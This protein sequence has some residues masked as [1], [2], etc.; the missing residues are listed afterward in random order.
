[1]F[2]PECTTSSKDSDDTGASTPLLGAPSIT[3]DEPLDVQTYCLFLLF[4]MGVSWAMPDL[5][6]VQVPYFERFQPESTNLALHF[7]VSVSITAVLFVPLYVWFRDKINYRWLMF[8]M[9]IVEITCCIITMLWWNVTLAD[10]SI[11]LYPA[12]FLSAM[13]GNVFYILLVPYFTKIN[14]YTC[15]PIL[16]GQTLGISYVS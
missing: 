8:G 10:L 3:S 4:G 6:W 2:P 5:L 1:M 16:A 14:N 13:V 12:A 9:L 11:I 15:A 7:S